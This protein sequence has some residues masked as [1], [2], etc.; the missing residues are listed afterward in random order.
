MLLVGRVSK[1]LPGRVRYPAYPVLLRRRESGRITR[2]SRESGGEPANI[3]VPEA[4][5]WQDTELV[6]ANV[7]EPDTLGTRLTLQPWEARVHRH[8]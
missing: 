6:L 8:R 4:D 2:V 1:L 3:E 7:P 5:R